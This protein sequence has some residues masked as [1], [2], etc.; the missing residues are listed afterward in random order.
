MFSIYYVSV[1]CVNYVFVILFCSGHLTEV[2]PT[3]CT[4]SFELE[5]GF[6]RKCM[7][8]AFVLMMRDHGSNFDFGGDVDVEQTKAKMHALK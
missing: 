7:L 1:L 3:S 4:S 8:S 6:K 5:D 2:A